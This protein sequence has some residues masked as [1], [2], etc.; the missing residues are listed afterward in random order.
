MNTRSKLFG[1]WVILAA[2][3]TV[4][5][6]LVYA[7][8][9]QNYRQ[10]AN[11]PQIEITQEISEA[12]NKGAPPDQIIP[13]SAG[14]DIKTSLAAFAMIFDKDGK[15]VGSSAKLNDKDPVP[16]K[17]VFDNAKKHGRNI[18]TWQP[19]K[20]VSLAAVVAPVKSGD[21]DYYILAGRNLREIEKREQSLALMSLITWV[22]LLL[23]S[24]LFTVALGTLLRSFGNI[25]EKDTEVVII[26]ET[27]ADKKSE[28]KQ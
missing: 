12:I 18:L 10:N 17:S 27:P 16:P 6:G 8:V 22:V 7:G 1:I 26:E 25:I 20:D 28:D 11:D 2:I 21:S 13:P 24:G 9:Q 5:V 4:L 14:T 23:L 19:E 15:V 3:M